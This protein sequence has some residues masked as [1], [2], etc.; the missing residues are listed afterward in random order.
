M[1]GIASIY[2]PSKENDSPFRMIALSGTHC[3]EAVVDEML[4]VFAHS[5][6]PHELVLV[7]VHSG[8][9]TNVSEDVLESICQ[10][11]GRQNTLVMKQ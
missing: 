8:Q 6:L 2:P 4:Q 5:D 3:V 9:L 11:Q 10:L 1:Q 7:A